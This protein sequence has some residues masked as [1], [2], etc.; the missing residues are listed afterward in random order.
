[1]SRYYCNDWKNIVKQE[2]E[3]RGMKCEVVDAN[4]NEIKA[5]EDKEEIAQISDTV[6]RWID[7]V[8]KNIDETLDSPYWDDTRELGYYTDKPGWEAYGALVMLCACLLLDCP[9]PEYVEDGWNAF[10]EP[11]VEKAMSQECPGSLLSNVMYWLPIP[12]MITFTTILPCGNTASFSTLDMLKRELEMLNQ[13][14]WNADETTILSWRNEKYYVP[15]KH[16]K[17]KLLFG[18]IWRTDKSRKEKYRTEELAQCAY[19]MLYYAVK[20]AEEHNVPVLL[21]Y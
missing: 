6:C 18:F 17:S 11:I 15:V 16:K 21:D 14:M 9:L 7:Y 1:M 5:V 4:G 10:E 20:F 13:K 19:S 8:T 12:K 2:A 3:R